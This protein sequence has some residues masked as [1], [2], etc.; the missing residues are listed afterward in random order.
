MPDKLILVISDNEALMDSVIRVAQAHTLA[1]VQCLSLA[2][3]RCTSQL[4]DA[5]ID[6]VDLFI[7]DLLR[8]YPGGMRAEGVALAHRLCRRGKRVLVISPLHCA[9]DETAQVYWDTASKD[10]LGSRIAECL[11]SGESQRALINAMSVRFAP[12]LDLPPQH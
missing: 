7:L 10:A 4:T 9:N 11:K 12:L 6:R 3:S 5:L 1:G 8:H 2:Y